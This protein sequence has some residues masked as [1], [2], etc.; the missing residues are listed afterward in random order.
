MSLAGWLGKAEIVIM[1]K[2]DLLVPELHRIFAA[3]PYLGNQHAK[4][5]VFQIQQEKK[6]ASELREWLFAL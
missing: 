2:T 5:L 6:L 4:I 1:A 3:D